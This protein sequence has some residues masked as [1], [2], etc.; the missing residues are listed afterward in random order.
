MSNDLSDLEKL[1]LEFPHA[2][3]NYVGLA[4]N[5]NIS[6]KFIKD[7]PGI[8]FNKIFLL[9]NPNIHLSKYILEHKIC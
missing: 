5:K 8:P 9:E 4:Y 3:W 2:N 6:F 7:N 1:V